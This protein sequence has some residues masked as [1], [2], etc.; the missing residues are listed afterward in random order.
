MTD[1]EAQ[2][3]KDGSPEKKPPCQ[4]TI[5]MDDQVQK[6][7]SLHFN[8]RGML[9]HCTNPAPL[10]KRLK[11]VLLFPGFRNPVEIQ[12]DVVWTNIH[13]SV[14]SHTP[15]GMGIKFMGVDRDMERMLNEL[16]TQYDSHKS[17]YS[18]YYS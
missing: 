12:G 17:I 18:C 8:E 3:V 1:K 10:D 16:A 6:G 2:A 14:D 13:G 4:V 11:L 9:V 5:F 7:T 15:R